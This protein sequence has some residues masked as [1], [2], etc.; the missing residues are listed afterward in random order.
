VTAPVGLFYGST[1]CYTEIVAE[2]IQ[3]L[4]GPNRIDI[5]NISQVNI[6]KTDL[7]DFI[8]FGIPTWDYG[9]LQEDW[10]LIWDDLSELDFNGKT[11]AIFGLGDQ[12]GYA[13]WFQDAIG[14]LAMQLQSQGA[15]LVGHWPNEGYVFDASKGLTPDSKYFYGLALDEENQAELTDQRLQQWLDALSLPT[16]VD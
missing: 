15:I 10:D 9:E 6:N 12:V 7:Y 13:Q 11:V 1:T 5:N 16:V 3:E 4:L 14:Y 2:R 8:I